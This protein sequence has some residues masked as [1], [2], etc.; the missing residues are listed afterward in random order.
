MKTLAD[1]QRGFTLLEAIVA[2]VLIAITLMPLYEW[3]GRSLAGM[4]KV[5]DTARQAEAQL[6]AVA[7]LAAVNP[8]EEPLGT[9]DTGSYRIRW[10]STPMTD[11]VDDTGYP[12]GVGLYLVA[13]YKVRAE[14]WRNDALWFA[15]DVDQVGFHRVRTQQVFQA[16]AAQP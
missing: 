16:P 10:R 12:R 15:F 3:V 7:V 6:S 9:V 11:P 4:S 14:I 8:M 5:A 2:L 13:L 1:R